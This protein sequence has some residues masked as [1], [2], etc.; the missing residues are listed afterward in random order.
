[1][2]DGERRL[3]NAIDVA[4][5]SEASTAQAAEAA[6]PVSAQVGYNERGRELRRP[7]DANE[8]SRYRSQD[9]S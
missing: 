2:V 6:L 1:M 4:Q 5:A 9:L 7:G 8:L 3:P